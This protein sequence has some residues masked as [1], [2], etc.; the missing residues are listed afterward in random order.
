MNWY[1]FYLFFLLEGAFSHSSRDLL[2][3]NKDCTWPWSCLSS[4]GNLALCYGSAY[5]VRWFPLNQ[6][7]F[8]VS[9]IVAFINSDTVMDEPPGHPT[10]DFHIGSPIA[11]WFMENP[12][13]MDDLGPYFR[14]PPKRLWLNV[15]RKKSQTW[16]VTT[17]APRAFSCLIATLCS[18]QCFSAGFTGWTRS[19]GMGA[20][21]NT[22]KHI[23]TPSCSHVGSQFANWV[24]YITPQ[25]LTCT[26]WAVQIRKS[27]KNLT[28]CS[29][30][31]KL[32]Q[33]PSPWWMFPLHLALLYIISYDLP[34]WGKKQYLFEVDMM[35]RLLDCKTPKTMMFI[36]KV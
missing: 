13:K 4:T 5:F 9:Q 11:G 33:V 16:P 15:R 3:S 1:D 36:E 29:L 19:W 23:Q 30:C 26:D 2:A 24:R 22:I 34:I 25:A 32:Q 20:C 7:W 6:W 17:Y 8:S 12:I 14:K 28:D 31:W 21:V 18:L 35:V 10:G 27:S